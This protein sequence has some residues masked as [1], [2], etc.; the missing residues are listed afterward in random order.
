[1]LQLTPDHT[2]AVAPP[3]PWPLP[4]PCHLVTPNRIF[5]ASEN[6]LQ[7]ACNVQAAEA[8]TAGYVVRLRGLP[9]SATTSDVLDFLGNP[10]MADM[11][12]PLVFT[13]TYDG[14]PTGEAY[15]ALGSQ[16]A[17]QAALAKHKEMLGPRYIEV[18][19]ATM[20]D[21]GQ[22]KQD[23]LVNAQQSALRMQWASAA[24]SGRP[25]MMSPGSMVQQ[26]PM[27]HQVQMGPGMYT[28]GPAAAGSGVGMPGGMVPVMNPLGMGPPM[29]AA[30]IQGEPAEQPSCAA[31]RG[32]FAAVPGRLALLVPPVACQLSQWHR[33][34]LCTRR[35]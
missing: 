17:Q 26:V 23:M 2:P 21:V 32:M 19:P 3:L 28:M 27:Q 30:P 35:V 12:D 11:D 8:A 14:R 22:A 20:S 16:A 15:M 31:E 4:T 5:E 24:A 1:V 7:T 29:A 13:Y 18:F 25:L 34:K 9:F 33:D 6:E 10:E